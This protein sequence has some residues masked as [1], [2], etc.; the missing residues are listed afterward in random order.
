MNFADNKDKKKIYNTRE[1]TEHQ[2]ETLLRWIQAQDKGGGEKKRKTGKTVE[3]KPTQENKQRNH[4]HS[5]YS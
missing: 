2:G 5:L 4:Q 3:Q 1:S